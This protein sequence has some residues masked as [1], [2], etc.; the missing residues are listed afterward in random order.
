MFYKTTLVLSLCYLLVI[1]E[2]SNPNGVTNSSVTLFD[3]FPEVQE[4]LQTIL[5]GIGSGIVLEKNEKNETVINLKIDLSG[6]DEDE[7]VSRDLEDDD[8]DLSGT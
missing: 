7:N 4:W 2:G 3:G 6:N 8:D 5:G 1:V